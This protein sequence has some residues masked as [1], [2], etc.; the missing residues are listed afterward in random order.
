MATGELVEG[1]LV[2]MVRVYTR[3]P[4]C[5]RCCSRTAVLMLWMLLVFWLACRCWPLLAVSLCNSGFT[6]WNAS[7]GAVAMLTLV[8]H[9]SL[10]GLLFH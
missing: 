6:T 3:S 5:R 2:C 9:T 1:G 10:A 4:T 7:A 8:L